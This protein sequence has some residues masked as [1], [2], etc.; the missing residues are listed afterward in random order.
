MGGRRSAAGFNGFDPLLVLLMTL[1]THAHGRT[2]P[3]S[4]PAL[5]FAL[6]S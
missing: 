2:G 6:T 1:K 4:V 3:V 5:P